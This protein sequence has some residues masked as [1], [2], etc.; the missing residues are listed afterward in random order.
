MLHHIA[1]FGNRAAM[2]FVGFDAAQRVARFVIYT[3]RV[4]EVFIEVTRN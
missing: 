2:P 3:G 4:Q 1:A